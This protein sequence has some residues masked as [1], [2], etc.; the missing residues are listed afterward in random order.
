MKSLQIL[1]LRQKTGNSYKKARS[2]SSQA[3]SAAVQV[4][5]TAING[6]IVD[7]TSISAGL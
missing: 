7:D 5:L 3:M 6:C 1:R 4:S 2:D